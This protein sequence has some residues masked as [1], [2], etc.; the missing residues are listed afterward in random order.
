M[1]LSN[2]KTY[3]NSTEVQDMKGEF[4]LSSSEKKVKKSQTLRVFFFCFREL[5]F[6]VCVWFG[7]R[8]VDQ[9]CNAM[10][11]NPNLASNRRF[12]FF[13][14]L[15]LIFFSFFL[16]NF[17]VSVNW[18]RYISWKWVCGFE[19]GELTSYAMQCN[20]MHPNLASN[21]IFHFFCF[22][23]LIIFFFLPLKFFWSRS[24]PAMQCNAMPCIPI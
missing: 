22:L 11:C 5:I 23:K 10:P 13:C 17:S 15:E 24:W 16:F 14:F 19:G 3:K 21:R 12:H 18:S 4:F 2:A 9:L 20:A 1:S 7:R 6:E 8:G